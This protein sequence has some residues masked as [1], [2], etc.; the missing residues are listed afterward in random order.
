M[1]I[2]EEEDI[3]KR[4]LLLRENAIKRVFKKYLQF[5]SAT[6]DNSSNPQS[7]ETCQNAYH[8]FIRELSSLELQIQ[9]ST[10]ISE[11]NQNE[12]KYYDELYSKRE[13][14]IESVKKEI[15]ELKT[16]L[17]Y[18]KIQR[19]YKEQYL[20]LY[21]LINE[22]NTTDQTEKEIQQVK[23]ELDAILD[24]NDTTSAKLDL[25]SKQFQ[26]L[27]HTV[28]ELE[29]SLDDEMVN[30]SALLQQATVSPNQ[31]SST[32]LG[33]SSTSIQS[34]LPPTQVLNGSNGIN[35]DKMV[36]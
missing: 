36:E 34:P 17:I 1:Q 32:S 8:S 6:A 20:A 19:Q 5:M 14:E 24:Q 2:D 11:I 21:K 28:Q 23:K 29:K 12:L 35:E 4:R 27:L 26:L 7:I 31:S 18:E 25:R 33:T 10:V 15:Q 30:P 13:E 16:R 3:L 9:K 22:K